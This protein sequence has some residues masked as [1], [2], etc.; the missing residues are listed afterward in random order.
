MYEK[1]NTKINYGIQIL[2]IIMSFIVLYHHCFNINKTNHKI[3]KFLFYSCPFCVPTFFIISYY[4]SYYIIISKNINKIKSRLERLVMPYFFYPIL[5]YVINWFLNI[6]DITKKD[7][8]FDLLI[9]IIC[10]K[11]IYIVFWFQCN[12][13]FT[14]ILFSIIFFSCRNL[15][16]I[17]IIGL[18]GYLYYNLHFA[19]KFFS[20]FRYEL[21][22]TFSDFSKTLFYGAFG[23]FFDYFE[24][25]KRIR[26]FYFKH[27]L[28]IIVFILFLV[29]NFYSFLDIYFFYLRLFIHV[30]VAI[31]LFTIFFSIPL[32]KINNKTMKNIIILFSRHSGGIYYLHLEIKKILSNKIIIIKE[33]T[34]LSCSLIYIICFLLS[35]LGYNLTKNIKLKYLF[36]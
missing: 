31:S 25:I 34:L 22:S 12:L 21:K 18:L 30:I 15:I 7:K 26:F 11:G 33:E 1:Q 27:L 28:I 9:Q 6:F 36:I 29:I 3:L 23:I 24:I 5:F 17:F 16:F 14:Y 32:E 20:N 19:Y 4:F 2:R 10:G 8:F 13:I 35:V